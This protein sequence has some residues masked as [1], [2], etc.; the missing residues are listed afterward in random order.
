MKWIN[1]FAKKI[2]PPQWW[3]VVSISSHITRFT[4]K[5][6]T[7]QSRLRLFNLYQSRHLFVHFCPFHNC[8]CINTMR[9]DYNL[10]KHG[11]C[12]GDSN[13]GPQDERMVGADNS[14]ELGMSAAMLRLLTIYWYN[15]CC[16]YITLDTDGLLRLAVE[17]YVDT[18]LLHVFISGVSWE[19]CPKVC[20]LKTFNS[21]KFWLDF[22]VTSIVMVHSN[23]VYYAAKYLLDLTVFSLH[24]RPFRPR[25]TQW[26]Q[27]YF[28]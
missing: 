1:C 18:V 9:F 26:C 12:P 4:Q 23:R 13:P 20:F 3:W 10:K 5:Y 7:N 25:N 8:N 27:R 2:L 17:T 24:K 21:C 11:L 22:D 16:K 15:I 19:H 14:T 6:F 28:R